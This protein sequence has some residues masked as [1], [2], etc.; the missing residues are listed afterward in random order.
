M[1]KGKKRASKPSDRIFV[2]QDGTQVSENELFRD[3]FRR[4]KEKKARES[5][6]A[7]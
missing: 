1:S 4:I 2:T 7:S 3:V 6:N 5:A